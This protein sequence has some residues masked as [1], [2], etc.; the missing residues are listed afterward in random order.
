ME[1]VLLVNV[2]YRG[3][4]VNIEKVSAGPK[5]QTPHFRRSG[6]QKWNGIS[7]AQCAR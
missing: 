5:N 7:L 6:I 1:L 4:I 2:I 3:S